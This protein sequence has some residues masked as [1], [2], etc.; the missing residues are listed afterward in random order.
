MAG[1]SAKHANDLVRAEELTG[2][3]Y[4]PWTVRQVNA[5]QSQL[6][7]EVRPG[8]DNHRDIT[9][10]RGAKQFFRGAFQIVIIGRF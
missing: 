3:S 4:V 9:V 1:C 10:I 7:G 6:A 8:F 2:V 5:I